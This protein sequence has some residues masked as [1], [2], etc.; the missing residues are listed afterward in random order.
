MVGFGAGVVIGSGGAATVPVLPDL[1]TTDCARPG[2][3]GR[4]SCSE[5]WRGSGGG[6][7]SRSWL[8]EHL[9]IPGRRRRRITEDKGL[10]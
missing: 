8:A 1:A 2:G 6:E 9:F 3:S 7:T 5:W 4:S 10:G